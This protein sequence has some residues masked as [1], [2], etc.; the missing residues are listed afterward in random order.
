MKLNLKNAAAAYT[1][2]TATSL[3]T[4]GVGIALARS[5]GYDVPTGPTLGAV[6][7]LTVG[8]PSTIAA[9]E[10]LR[11][12]LGQRKP[13]WVSASAPTRQVKVGHPS[14][15]HTFL[16]TIPLLKGERPNLPDEVGPAMFKVSLDGSIVEVPEPDVLEFLRLVWRRQQDGRHGLSQRWWTSKRRPALS[17]QDYDARVAVLTGTPNLIV[18]RDERRSGRLVY[19]PLGALRM[20]KSC[21]NLTE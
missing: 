7:L 8:V 3:A 20:V 10:Q 4:C 1:A 13:T 12:A 16:S 15:T 17:R 11:R 19:P 2:A 21:Y 5:L 14:L 9:G 6:W 18:N